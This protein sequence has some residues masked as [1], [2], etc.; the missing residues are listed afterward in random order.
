[1]S[2]L[3]FGVPPP[4]VSMAPDAF[5]LILLFIAIFSFVRRFSA[6]FLSLEFGLEVIA[7]ILNLLRHYGKPPKTSEGILACGYLSRASVAIINY[8]SVGET[9]EERRANFWKGSAETALILRQIK[10]R[11]ERRQQQPLQQQQQ[12]QL[13]QQQLQQQQLQQHKGTCS[14]PYKP[15]EITTTKTVPTTDDKD[16]L[17]IIMAISA[18]PGNIAYW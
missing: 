5:Y 3:L 2:P 11:K 16:Q 9:Y 6:F 10:S 7:S 15:Y 13:Q 12:Q 4:P 14:V 1:M 17:N 18:D 8:V